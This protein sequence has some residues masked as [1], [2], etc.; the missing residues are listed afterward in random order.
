M[1]TLI[2]S[3]AEVNSPNW[4]KWLDSQKSFRFETEAEVP[5]ANGR[6]TRPQTLSFTAVK[7][8]KK[9]YWHAHK[10]VDGKL[11]RFYLGSADNVTWDKL[12]EAAATL[13][14]DALW[15]EY[16]N[17][18]QKK[19]QDKPSTTSPAAT[20][21]ELK[22][23]VE[24]LRAELNTTKKELEAEAADAAKYYP[25]WRSSKGLRTERDFLKG[26]RDKLEDELKDLREELKQKQY[27]VTWLEN[28]NARLERLKQDYGHDIVAR[29]HDKYAKVL[30]ENELIKG[31]RDSFKHQALK[32]SQL[33]DDQKARSL[34][35]EKTTSVSDSE[36]IPSQFAIAAEVLSQFIEEKELTQKLDQPRRYRDISALAQFQ[37]WLAISQNSCE[38]ASTESLPSQ[39]QEHCK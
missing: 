38:T 23:E 3:L 1:T 35:E 28:E 7:Q 20:V 18:K 5:V 14:I 19:K 17:Q 30:R 31:Q 11:R 10:R 34:E 2:D 32:L 22:S 36:Q 21:S 39:N 12:C 24:R 33:V 8:G 26:Q 16:E 4:G 25:V 37:K 29:L 9:G 6:F 27:R 13:T 15:G